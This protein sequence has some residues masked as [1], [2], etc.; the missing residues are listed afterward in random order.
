MQS[1]EWLRVLLVVNNTRAPG[2]ANLS[3]LLLLDNIT[4]LRVRDAPGNLT[5]V[6]LQALRREKLLG[7]AGGVLRDC[8]EWGE[9]GC[10][11]RPTAAQGLVRLLLHLFLLSS[12]CS[13]SSSF[14]FAFF[15]HLFS[16]AFSCSLFLFLLFSPPPCSFIFSSIFSSPFVLLFS[17]SFSSSSPPLPLLPSPL[18][19]FFAQLCSDLTPASVLRDPLPGGARGTL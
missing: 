11:A 3:D 5:A 18:F 14:S 12:S 9:P 13:S 4:G 17:L 19:L 10:H 16:F 2:A 15:L 8:R 7:E 6:G 1:A